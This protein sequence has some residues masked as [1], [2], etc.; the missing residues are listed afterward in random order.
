MPPTFF[1]F[2]GFIIYLGLL[3][4][5]GLIAGPMLLFKQY[6]QQGKLII[7]T[8][9]ISFPTLLI[10]GLTL[11]ILFALP[12]LVLIFLLEKL[13][14]VHLTFI[15]FLIF[16]LT[17]AVSALYHWYLGH[18]IIKN[19]VYGR[20]LDQQIENDKI[21]SKFIKRVVKYYGLDRKT[22]N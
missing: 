15:F 4:L 20:P 11:T 3:G 1:V 12:G 22:I 5:S 13:N 16:V 21:Y 6:R 18:I 17:V 10:V 2:V 9:I 19:Y 14:L 8:T 7:L